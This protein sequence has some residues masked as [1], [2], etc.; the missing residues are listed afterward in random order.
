MPQDENGVITN[1]IIRYSY[2][3][4]KAPQ[5][6]QIQVNQYER[7]FSLN[8]LNYFTEYVIQLAAKTSAGIGPFSKSIRIQTD[9]N[10]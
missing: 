2:D 1:Y 9:Q 3:R 10:G 7:K 4:F 5:R 6:H 8:N